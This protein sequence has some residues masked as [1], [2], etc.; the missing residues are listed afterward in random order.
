MLELL[1]TNDPV[2]LSFAEAVL[3]DAGITVLVAD[4]HTSIIEGSIGIF[5]RRM[6]VHAD[7]IGRA[8][9]ALVDAGLAKHLMDPAP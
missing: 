2:L 8:R 6:L 5:P 4:R 1:R 9:V 3:G 7:D